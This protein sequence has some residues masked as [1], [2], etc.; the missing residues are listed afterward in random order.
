MNTG[1]NIKLL[2]E[3]YNLTQLQLGE[4]A[5]VSDK[6]VSTWEKG[7][8]EPRM[9][10]VQKIADYFG[11]TK[12]RIIEGENGSNAVRINVYGSVPAGI[13]LEA[14]EDILGWEEIPK[15]WTMSDQKYIGLK[16]TGD[17]MSPKYLDGD[18]IILRLQPDCESGQDCVV[19]VNGYEAKLKRVIKKPDGIM[20]QPLNPEYE[21]VFY[22]YNGEY[23][24]VII[25]GVVFEIRRRV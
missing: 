19:Y 14:I 3:K 17:C 2:R 11:T 13:P 18:I 22:S 15:E 20:L 8:K 4:I 12:S 9:G 7:L 1:T 5:G 21:P 23:N 25:L 24:P 6:A 10:A 16:V